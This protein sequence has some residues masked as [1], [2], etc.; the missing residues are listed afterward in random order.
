MIK[1]NSGF[2]EGLMAGAFAFGANRTSTD[3][4]NFPLASLLGHYDKG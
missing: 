3:K 1:A 2:P 4:Y